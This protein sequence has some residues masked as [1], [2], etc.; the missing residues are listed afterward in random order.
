MTFHYL[1]RSI[2]S[3]AASLSLALLVTA[4][5]GPVVSG[6]RAPIVEYGA[7]P[8]RAVV[9][10]PVGNI[11]FYVVQAGD[12]L[13]SIAFENGLDYM[14]VAR[15]NG[16]KD[17]AAIQ[18]G[19]KLRLLTPKEEVVT[20]APPPPV[21][22]RI[23]QMGEIKTQPKVGRL[24]Y[25]AQAMAKAERLQQEGAPSVS[26][27][28]PVARAELPP[29]ADDSSVEWGM[30]A[31]GQLIAGYSQSANRK[32]V[33]IGGARGQPIF[34]SAA[35]KVVYSG[36]GLRGYGKLI[37]IKHNSTFLSAYAHNERL[38]VK[39]GQT[40]RKGQQIAEMG[41]SDAD[42][43]KLHF[44]IRKLGKPV[45]PAKYLPLIKS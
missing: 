19:Q 25:N 24:L 26:A 17:P 36:T 32:G 44:E 37:I 16:L 43:V 22:T 6:K 23:P 5:A 42:Q 4:C 20:E 13:Y 31:R 41:S 39:E 11:A 15:D 45:D 40:V 3:I 9:E 30:P 33:D 28:A 34:A 14:D 7:G 12:T 10:R 21:V 27:P 18:V 29:A 1:Q 8:G 35:G 2:P 38:M